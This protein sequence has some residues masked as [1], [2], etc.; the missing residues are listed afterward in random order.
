MKS[1][2]DGARQLNIS[3][4]HQDEFRPG[5]FNTE[6]ITSHIVMRP[7]EQRVISALHGDG[8]QRLIV[9]TIKPQPEPAK[10]SAKAE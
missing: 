6:N 4:L 10:S 8:A 7:G 3:F 5:A 9:A 1:M 2:T